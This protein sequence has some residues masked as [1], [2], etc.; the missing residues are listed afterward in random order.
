MTFE[1]CFN[2]KAHKIN[3]NPHLHA[4]ILVIYIL[5]PGN[6]LTGI[7]TISHRLVFITLRQRNMHE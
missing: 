7:E 1:K 3:H 6:E 4:V 5:D 2:E